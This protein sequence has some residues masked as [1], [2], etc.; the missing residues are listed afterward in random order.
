[1]GTPGVLQIHQINRI[2]G[3]AMLDRFPIPYVYPLD[4]ENTDWIVYG[5]THQ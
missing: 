5:Y 2:M 4:H 1:M 3:L